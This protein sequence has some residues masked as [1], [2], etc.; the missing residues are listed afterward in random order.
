MTFGI[1]LTKANAAA[2]FGSD[3]QFAKFD[4]FEVDYGD[5]EEN[6]IPLGITIF[7]LVCLILSGILHHALF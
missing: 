1:N 5:D 6:V 7:L 3:V 4:G 2:V